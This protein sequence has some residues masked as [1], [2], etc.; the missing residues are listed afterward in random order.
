MI[1]EH[2]V[3]AQRWGYANINTGALWYREKHGITEPNSFDEPGKATTMENEYFVHLGLEVPY[4][5]WMED[6]S[7]LHRGTYLQTNGLWIHT[8]IDVWARADT[9]V[10][11]V[12]AGDVMYQGTDWPMIGGWGY[13]IIQK[14][15]FRGQPHALVYAHLAHQPARERRTKYPKDDIIGHIGTEKDNGHWSQHLHLQLFADVED[16]TDWEAFS[17]QIDGYVRPD[18]CAKWAA[19]CPDPTP[20]IFK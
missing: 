2:K 20:L 5:G 3:M 18:E 10:L 7:T 4:G 6:R 12:A 9:I 19:K 1:F 16:V 17:Q 15:N 11:A 13:H 8:G 14:I